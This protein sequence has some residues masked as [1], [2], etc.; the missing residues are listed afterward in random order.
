MSD[1][2]AMDLP[3]L[4]SGGGAAAA[5]VLADAFGRAD[6]TTTMGNTDTGQTWSPFSG[7]WGI[8]SN[9]AYLVSDTAQAVTVF[10]AGNA[11]GTFQV[12]ITTSP[13]LNKVDCG[14]VFRSI[15]STKHLLLAINKNAA[16]NAVTLWKV[17]TTYTK[18]AEFNP[19]S[20]AENT[21]YTVAVG[22]AGAD[23][24]VSINGTV[25][26]THTLVGADATQFTTPTLIGIRVNW[27]FGNGGDDK[28]SRFDNLSMT[29][30]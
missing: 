14:L 2:L 15:S 29:L 12:E 30:P 17:D 11:D 6:S 25:R 20:L 27:F 16:T 13:T 1:Y 22:L 4:F 10:D 18:L 28:S 3:V 8:S 24:T 21:L 5:V 7:T 9:K 19:A 26:I 23:I